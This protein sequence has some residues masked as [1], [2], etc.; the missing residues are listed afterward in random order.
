MPKNRRRKNNFFVQ[1]CTFLILDSSPCQSC[2]ISLNSGSTSEK[3]A[4]ERSDKI[5]VKRVFQRYS[6]LYIR[7]PKRIFTLVHSGWAQFVHTHPVVW[8]KWKKI[9]SR[10]D[11]VTYSLFMT[12]NSLC[13]PWLLVPIDK[14]KQGNIDQQH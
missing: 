2:Q 8:Q 3:S 11:V 14:G 9:W 12:H 13:T 4:L 10:R 5:K 7:Q 1:F 6:I